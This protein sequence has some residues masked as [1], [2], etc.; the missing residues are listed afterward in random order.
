MTALSLIREPYASLL[1]RFVH[2]TYNIVANASVTKIEIFT[3]AEALN[4]CLQNTR[5]SVL[6]N[7]NNEVS[8]LKKNS[9][10][11]FKPVFDFKVR[12]LISGVFNIFHAY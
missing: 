9:K 10:I 6:T 3:L 8:E 5:T 4:D 1:T 7:E 11:D 12:K 2:T